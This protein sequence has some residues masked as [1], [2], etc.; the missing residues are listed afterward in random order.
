MEHQEVI[1]ADYFVQ[2]EIWEQFNTPVITNVVSVIIF[3]IYSD[4]DKE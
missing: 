3:V 2:H 4:L 1:R